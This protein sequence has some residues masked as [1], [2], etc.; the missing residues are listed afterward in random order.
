M[1]DVAAVLSFLERQP[2]VRHG[3]VGVTGYC[4]G[5]R[6]A[7]AAAGHFQDHI[8]AVASYHAG[9][10]A[11]DAPDSPHRFVPRI[12]GRVYVAGAVEDPNFDDAQK[13]RLEDALTAAHVDHK[14]ETYPARHGWV[15]SDTPVHDPRA[16]E[17]H[18]DTLFDL[19]DH[20]LGEGAGATAAAP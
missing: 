17:R 11:T 7:L 20:A 14:V 9:G 4:L 19:F 15:P 10:L 13:Q 12:R 18:W 3:K 2:K 1:P 16:A 5:G 8:A 6:V